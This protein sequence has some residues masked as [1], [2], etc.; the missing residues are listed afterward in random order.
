[1][2]EKAHAEGWITFATIIAAVAGTLN[3][4]FGLAAMYKL[5]PFGQPEV[6]YLS[7]YVFGLI[8]LF[9]GV[10]QIVTAVLL[11]RRLMMGRWFGIFIA[12]SSMIL[13]SFWIGAYQTASLF[14]LV[15]DTLVIYGLAVTGEHFTS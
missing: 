4:V 10:A 1:M 14:A 6:L 2:P 8:L 7:T 11:S 15:L 13:W 9:I 3:A 12:A 5:G